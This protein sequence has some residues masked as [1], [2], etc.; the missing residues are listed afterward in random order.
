MREQD[1]CS[2]QGMKNS[3]GFRKVDGFHVFSI[4]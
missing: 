3:P 1:G 4:R 2:A